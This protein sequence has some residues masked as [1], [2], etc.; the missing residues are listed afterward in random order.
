MGFELN[1]ILRILNF[2][3]VGC[4]WAV[5]SNTTVDQ[6]GVCGGDGKTCTTIKNEFVKKLNMSEGYY[7][8][9]MIPSGSRN[10]LVE[11]LGTSKNFI[12]IA[13]ANTKEF[14]LNGDK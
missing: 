2:Q 6:C 10:I 7:E 12:G 14:Y 3:K 13:N 5:D 11:E 9:T 1:K 8:I 4:D